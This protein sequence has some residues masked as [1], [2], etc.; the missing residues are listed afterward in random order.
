MS[1]ARWG[2]LSRWK[3]TPWPARFIFW[4]SLP[5]LLLGLV[6]IYFPRT[7]HPALLFALAVAIAS[8][9]LVDPELGLLAG[10]AAALGLVLCV[11]AAL[12]ARSS[13]EPPSPSTASVHGSSQGHV[14]RG[15][16]EM[17]H[18]PPAPALQ[19][20]TATNPLAPNSGEAES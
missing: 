1:T 16:T 14:E 17:Y 4:C 11:V 9:A 12:L 5:V 2:P 8:S 19:A 13:A 18:R 20:S 15:V 3:C 10:Q 7:R 6:F